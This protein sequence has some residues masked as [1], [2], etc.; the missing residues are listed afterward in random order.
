MSQPKPSLDDLRIE[1]RSTSQA[2]PGIWFWMS[3]IL[4]LLLVGASFWWFK[5]ASAITVHTAL[6]RE[7]SSAGNERTVL[8][9]SGY[10]TA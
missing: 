7:S 4:V 10:V 1:R 5:G 8:N 3:L 6:V 2:N 9:A